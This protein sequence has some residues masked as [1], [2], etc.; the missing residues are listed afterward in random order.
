M[1]KLTE[2]RFDYDKVRDAIESAYNWSYVESEG[3]N[4]TRFDFNSDRDSMWI[5]SKGQVD[6]NIPRNPGLKRALRKLGIKE[7]IIREGIL[8]EIRKGDWIRSAYDELGLVNKVKGQTAYVS[9]DGSRSFHPIRVADLKKTKEFHRGKAVYSEGKLTEDYSQRARNFRVNLRQRLKAMKKGQ[10]VGIGKMKFSKMVDGNFQLKGKVYGVEEVVQAIQKGPARPHIKTHRGA[11]GADMVNA[12]LKFE[13]KLTESMIGIKT[14]ANF[15]PI[16]LKGA[17]ERAGIKGFRMDRL[18]VSLTA[19]KLDKK[20]YNDAKNIIDNLG[21]SV[22]MAKESVNEGQPVFQTTPNEMAYIDFKKWAYKNR[23]AVKGILVKAIKDGREPGTDVFLALRQVWLA[24]AKKNAKEWSRIPNKDAAGSKFGRAL[25]VMMKKD[26]LIITKSG[27]KLTD[28]EEG[29]LTEDDL[30]P[31]DKGLGDRITIPKGKEVI[32]QADT[33]EHERGLVVKWKDDGGYDVAYWYGTPDKIVPAELRGAETPS[34]DFRKHGESYGD[35]KHVWLGYHPSM[36]K[37]YD[38]NVAPDHDGKA[39]PYGSGYDELQERLKKGESGCCHKCG[40]S[41]PKGGT[42]PTPYKSGKNS[43]ASRKSES[44]NVIQYESTETSITE[45]DVDTPEELKEFVSFLKEYKSSVNE[46]EY[47][48][49]KV[50]LGK[51]TQGDVKKFK[52]YVTNPKGNVVKVNFGQKGMVIKKDNPGAKKSF[53][54]RH[55]CDAPGP[56]HKAR[57]WSCRKW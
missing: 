53:R 24:W 4:R 13:G 3:P 40:H 20:Y 51:P 17:L 55:N 18:S 12:Y 14:K 49:R 32:L 35:V 33:T 6:G 43:C 15:K 16:Q 8:N 2:I 28:M 1:K 11:A 52:V 45:Y 29:K 57:Y 41:H 30:P 10:K 5:D 31:N 38:E 7:S 50:K 36:D 39:A 37:T 23:K 47:E 46:A 25:A 19:L 48:G 22:M 9:F 27:N 26:N 44:S 56:R 54:A 42:H 34:E 21:L